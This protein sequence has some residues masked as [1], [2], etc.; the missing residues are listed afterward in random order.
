MYRF[1][2]L[3]NVIFLP[4]IALITIQKI[5]YFYKTQE[6]LSL[7]RKSF[8]KYNPYLKYEFLKKKYK[9]WMGKVIKHEGFNEYEIN[10]NKIAKRDDVFFTE[11]NRLYHLGLFVPS[12]LYAENKKNT[13]YTV[14]KGKL[15]TKPFP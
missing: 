9:K 8:L 14:C 2:F 4:F 10:Y 11:L 7:Y 15:F 6:E 1:L 12:L 13:I 5:Q 3:S